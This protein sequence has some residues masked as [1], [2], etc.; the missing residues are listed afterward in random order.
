LGGSRERERGE[1][2]GRLEKVKL[3]G[4]PGL[5]AGE[6][7]GKE[8]E[9]GWAL[10]KKKQGARVEVSGPKAEREGG[11]PTSI[12]FLYQIFQMKF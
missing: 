4:R 3:T 10:P 7:E 2:G 9:A 12:Y 1:R 5:S 6:R 8:E 11:I